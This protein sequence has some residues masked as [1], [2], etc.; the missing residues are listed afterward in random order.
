[1]RALVAVFPC[2]RACAAALVLLLAAPAAASPREAISVR[3]ESAL[4]ES[5]LAKAVRAVYE[6]RD[7]RPLWL[8]EDG[9]AARALQL[10]RA[11]GRAKP[12]GLE[13]RD[14][15]IVALRKEQGTASPADPAARELLITRELLSYAA[16][17]RSGRPASRRANPALFGR[18]GR[19]DRAAILGEA[20]EARD[21][22]RFLAD[23]APAN[24][25]YR[26]LR[27]E[28][29]NLRAAAEQGGWPAIRGRWALREGDQGRR[30]AALRRR[31]AASGD[32]TDSGGE[33]DAFDERVRFAVE[34]FQRRHGLE[35]DGVVGRGT[36]EALGV[37]VEERI[38]QVLVNMERARWLPDD[39]GRRY[40][41]VNLAGFELD[42]V[43]DGWPVMTM[44]I[45]VGRPYRRTPVFSSR[46][47]HLELN[48][49]WTVPPSIARKDILPLVRRDPDYLARNNIRVFAGWKAGA[50]ELDPA[51]ID[52]SRIRSRVPYMLRQD[53][54][55]DNALGLVKF[56]IPN[57]HSI[58]LHDTPQQQLF[59]RRLRTF[60]SGCI[61]LEQPMELA[62][63]LLKDDP[64]WTGERVQEALGSGEP[65]RIAVKQPVDLHMTY[66]TAWVDRD[67]TA[68]F[69]ADPYGRD[70]ELARAIFGARHAGG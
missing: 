48:P 32:L 67:G 64:A 51:A 39:L 50:R 44:K 9:G 19:I 29:A 20:A 65:T 53:P 63:Y 47:T 62:D 66:A 22:R 3:I 31:L 68:H 16:D 10:A 38:R 11:L 49:T 59:D 60:S 69:R 56:L 4:A 45:I 12:E 41:K 35:P 17:L 57:R 52:W 70:E 46:L 24:P 28:L 15:A 21:L 6:A 23:L 14:R 26:G 58:F 8:G 34:R 25:V 2:R 37:T 27:R 42:L 30:V 18:A 1:M 55:V 40:I 5:G 43:E 7:F 61:R 54:G 13:P 33:P 36:R